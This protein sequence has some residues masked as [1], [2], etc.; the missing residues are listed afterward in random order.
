MKPPGLAVQPPARVG[1][2]F[3]CNAVY[4]PRAACV[5]RREGPFFYRWFQAAVVF[6]LLRS[7]SFVVHKSG[8]VKIKSCLP[9]GLNPLNRFSQC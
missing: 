1:L 7:K 6:S 3:R 2:L 8:F 5:R 4:V 9:N